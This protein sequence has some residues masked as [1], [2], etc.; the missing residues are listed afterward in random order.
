MVD[1]NQYLPSE[2][3]EAGWVLITANGINDAGM[4]V[5]T[6]YNARMGGTLFVLKP[7]KP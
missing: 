4:I 6:A 3:S 2:L 7:A 5:G 1:L